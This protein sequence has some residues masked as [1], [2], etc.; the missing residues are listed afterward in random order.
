MVEVD[1]CVYGD[2]HIIQGSGLDD[3][4][5]LDNHGNSLIVKIGDKVCYANKSLYHRIIC[6]GI[7][8]GFDRNEHNRIHISGISVSVSGEAY[9][10]KLK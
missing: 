1:G 9:I 4:M 8:E 2:I 10:G 7:V 3:R 5:L 6:T